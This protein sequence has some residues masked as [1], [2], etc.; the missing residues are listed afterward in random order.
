M[1]TS[2]CMLIVV[3][4]GLHFC[5]ANG[6]TPTIDQRS[7]EAG[8]K[9]TLIATM[10]GEPLYLGQVTS[11]DVEIK[12][13]ELPRGE[14]DEWLRQYRG[15]RTYENIWGAV[16]RRYVVRE[17]LSVSE[18]ELAAITKSVE[19]RLKSAPE[20]PNGTTITLAERKG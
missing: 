14:F 3:F 11:A 1:R 19:R 8:N 7:G 16:L 4:L 6:D 15:R 18:E 17:K 12:Q 9:Q 2:G 10:F 13:K 5:A 20:M